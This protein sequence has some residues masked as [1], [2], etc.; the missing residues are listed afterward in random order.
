MKT[1][2]KH[3]ENHGLIF[4]LDGFLA[5][6]PSQASSVASRLSAPPGEVFF[7]PFLF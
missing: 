1:T 5:E 3:L 7:E 2:F 6:D 4:L